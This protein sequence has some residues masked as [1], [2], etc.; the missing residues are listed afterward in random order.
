MPAPALGAGSSK[1]HR[2]SE[3][4]H[5]LA[6]LA[7][8]TVAPRL[9]EKK[10][11]EYLQEGEEGEEDSGEDSMHSSEDG[12]TT[13]T[14]TWT[15]ASRK[16]ETPEQKKIRKAAAKEQQSLRRKN[17]K[18]MRGIYSEEQGKAIRADGKRST[19]EHVSVFRY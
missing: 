16:A 14:A 12:L 4:R 6:T 11:T 17:K 5:G 18:T 2:H 1:A 19:L 8:E 15:L 3:L 10:P 9:R 13:G 7:E